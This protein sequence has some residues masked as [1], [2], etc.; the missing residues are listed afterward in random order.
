MIGRSNFRV[1]YNTDADFHGQMTEV[2][3]WAGERTQAQIRENMFKSLT[4]GEANLVGLWNFNDPSQ[5]GK[6]SSTN[7]HHGTLEG[8]ARVVSAPRPTRCESN[9]PII[10]FGKVLDS[11]G[12][13]ATNAAIRLLRQEQEVATTQSRPDGPIPSVRPE[14]ALETFDIQTSAGD[15]GTFG[16]RRGVCG[17]RAQRSQLHPRQRGEY[18]GQGHGF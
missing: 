14:P 3:M 16:I 4:G 9:L 1:V 8:Q 5:P 2:R 10:L 11:L 18:C 12:N 6:D 13:P 15:L 7:A 17:R